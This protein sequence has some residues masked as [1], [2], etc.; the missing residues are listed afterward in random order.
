MG[1]ALSKLANATSR[2]LTRR[3]LC[4]IDDNADAVV[5]CVYPFSPRRH[6]PGKVGNILRKSVWGTAKAPVKVIH[7]CSHAISETLSRP[8]SRTDLS[9]MAQ[10]DL[11][12]LP[13]FDQGA[14]HSSEAVADPNLTRAGSA[15]S[16]KPPPPW[17][18]PAVPHRR[19]AFGERVSPAAGLALNMGDIV[20]EGGSRN[21]PRNHIRNL[22]PEQV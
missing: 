10:A 3:Y 1:R 11:S 2:V 7:A 17:Q 13:G 16:L 15:S 14:D 21:S 4:L 19:P 9:S 6:L 12:Q 18:P 8:A 20:N 5:V 22:S